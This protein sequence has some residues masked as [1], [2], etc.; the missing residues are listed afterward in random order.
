MA[1]NNRFELSVQLQ[2]VTVGNSDAIL[3]VT[4]L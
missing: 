3:L 1:E 2:T 4:E